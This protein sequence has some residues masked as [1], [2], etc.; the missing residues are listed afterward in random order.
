ME[1]GTCGEGENV[2]EKRCEEE[3][4]ETG[5][6]GGYMK[7][8]TSGEKRCVKKGCVRK[9]MWRRR[10]MEKGTCGKDGLNRKDVGRGVLRSE[11]IEGDLGERMDTRMQELEMR[12]SGRR[13]P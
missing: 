3:S 2:R 13:K 10:R 5:T 11:N 4:V 6:C 9:G 12:D 8:G 7:K 1:K